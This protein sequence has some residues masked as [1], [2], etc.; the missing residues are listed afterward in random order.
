MKTTPFQ[1]DL[2][3]RHHESASKS[4]THT[5]IHHFQLDAAGIRLREFVS[6]GEGANIHTATQ[7]GSAH[8]PQPSI[9]GWFTWSGSGWGSGLQMY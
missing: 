5:H 6:G 9:E 7:A 1:A 4:Y 2:Q 3:F 8:E